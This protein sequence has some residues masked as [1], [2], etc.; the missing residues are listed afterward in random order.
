MSDT[1]IKQNDGDEI[2]IDDLELSSDFSEN[3]IEDSDKGV[4]PEV[5]K[6]DD[7]SVVISKSKLVLIKTILSNLQT[8]NE[9]LLKLLSSTVSSEDEERISIAQNSDAVFNLN[10][11]NTNHDDGRIIEG[12]FDGEN[13]IGPDGKQYSVPANYASKSKLIEGD[14]LKLT[15][16]SKGTFV[17]KQIKPIDRRR[18]MGILSQETSGNYIVSA[19]DSKWHVLTASVTYYK[20]QIGDEIVLIVPTNGKSKWG[21]VDNIVKNVN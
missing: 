4:S 13:M 20:G 9:Q 7:D 3:K 14:S 8:S 15:I 18:V 1:K 21:A 10:S 19:E 17:Y 16:T 5:E 6:S 12:I 2:I 11:E